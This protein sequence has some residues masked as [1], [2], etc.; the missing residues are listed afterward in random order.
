MENNSFVYF[1]QAGTHGPVKIG[2]AI[3]PAKRLAELQTAHYSD[4]RIIYQTTENEIINESVLHGVF[5]PFNIRGEWFHPSPFIFEFIGDLKFCKTNES[6]MELINTFSERTV[7][8]DYM[9]SCRVNFASAL[10]SKRD[11]FIALVP[12]LRDSIARY[13]R[14]ER[15]DVCRFVEKKFT[16]SK[17]NDVGFED[18]L[19]DFY[20]QH[21]DFVA[22]NLLPIFSD[23]CGHIIKITANE[24]V[25]GSKESVLVSF[26]SWV[27]KHARARARTHCR[28][29]RR[30][31]LRILADESAR[32]GED[33][34]S[35][36][37]DLFYAW[38]FSGVSFED[39]AEQRANAEMEIFYQLSARR[40]DDHIAGSKQ[41]QI[42]TS[43]A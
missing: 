19:E 6:V 26:Y 37:L 4:L 2:R 18:W 9:V 31:I 7:G 36:I 1:V 17:C 12:L 16:K 13:V 5:G 30:Q 33:F 39:L 40:I 32:G 25:L 24:C 3:S 41:K 35:R 23:S 11:F 42:E 14:R 38:E 21:V 29:Q 43:A 15:N 27:R 10:E 28:D 34:H 22:G 8:L 20:E